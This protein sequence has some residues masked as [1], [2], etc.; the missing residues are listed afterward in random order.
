MSTVRCTRPSANESVSATAKPDRRELPERDSG[1]MTAPARIWQRLGRAQAVERVKFAGEFG[2][3][4]GLVGLQVANQAPAQ[5][6]HVLAHGLPLAVGL[7]HFVFAHFAHA[8]GPGQAQ[9][10]LGHGLLTGQQANV[11]RAAAA[12]LDRKSV[13]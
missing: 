10:L 9:A 4:P 1:S 8:G 12:S 13:V 11:L 3:Q 5:T 6:G 7:L 2:H